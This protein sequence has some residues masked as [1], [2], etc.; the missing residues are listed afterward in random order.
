MEK[1]HG[2]MHVSVLSCKF[3]TSKHACFHVFFSFSAHLY[4]PLHH[5]GIM[6]KGLLQKIVCYSHAFLAIPVC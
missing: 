1:I 2:N 6:V 3:L 5:N 4:P